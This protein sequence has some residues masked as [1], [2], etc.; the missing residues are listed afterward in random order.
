MDFL[1][2]RPSGPEQPPGALQYVH[3]A[4]RLTYPGGSVVSA[5]TNWSQLG[6]AALTVNAGINSATIAGYLI[7]MVMMMMVMNPRGQFV[8]D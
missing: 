8:T 7:R 4:A 1:P 5:R 2:R 3:V 6:V